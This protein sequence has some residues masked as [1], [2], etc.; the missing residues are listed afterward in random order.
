MAHGLPDFY[1]GVDIAYQALAQII[2]RPKY[3]A[4]E[5]VMGGTPAVANGEKVV[6]SVSGKGIL[7]GGYVYIDHTSTQRDSSVYIAIDG[8]TMGGDF[9]KY[10]NQFSL[11]KPRSAL[12]YKLLYDDTIF[13]YSVA[14]SPDITFETSLSLKYYERHGQTPTIYYFLLYAL[15]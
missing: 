14:L 11:D 5:R 7:Y 10:L 6:C 4:A 8:V 1:R 15:I 2:V 9:F 3:G 13:E 12:C